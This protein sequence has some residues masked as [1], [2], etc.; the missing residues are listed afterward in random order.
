MTPAAITISIMVQGSQLDRVIENQAGR[1][2][3]SSPTAIGWAIVS[4]S[5]ST[6]SSPSHRL[7]TTVATPLPTRLV[8][9]RHSLMNLS[10][11]SKIARDWMGTSG[12]IASVAASVT[13]PAPVTPEAPF[14]VTIA[15]ARM[16]SR[17]PNVR[18][19]LVAWAKKQRCQ[20]HIDVRAIKIETVTGG[21][22]QPDDR[23]RGAE[24]LHLLNHVRQNGLRRRRTEDNEQLVLDVG[25]ETQ[26]G[27]TGEA[28]NGA[29]HQHNKQHTRQIKR[30]DQLQEVHQGRDTIGS[31][32]EGHGAECTYWRCLHDNPDHTEENLGHRLDDAVDFL[33]E[34]T[35]ARYR[36]TREDRYKQDLQKVA[37][38][39]GANECVRNDCQQV[40]NDAFFLR[41]ADVPS[42]RF[43]IQAC[44]I[45]VEAFAGL[46]QFTDNQPKSERKRGNGLEIN[47]GFD[48]Y[49][50]DFLEVAHRSDP[51]HHRAKDHRANHHLDERDE[52]AA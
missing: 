44:H 29:K 28:C 46:Q 12:T 1:A 10:M 42:D 2:S 43:G 23:L 32:G 40:G 17:C 50:A 35:K 48:A 30:R 9:A 18:G 20:C 26:N 39:K 38:G 51:V 14:E 21:D 36:K 13:N 5:L 45:N 41:L 3:S 34:I 15:I 49:A 52:A 27:E 22:H 25:D 19:G 8:R 24:V 6:S 33:T 16:P 47:Q 37:F 11:P 4:C 7:M 31:D